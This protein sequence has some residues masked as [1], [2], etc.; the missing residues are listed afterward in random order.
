MSYTSR[1]FNS[2]TEIDPGY[3]A[4]DFAGYFDA[5]I[6]HGVVAGKEATSLKVERTTGLGVSV[7]VGMIIINGYMGIVHSAPEAFTLDS[8]GAQNRTDAVVMRLDMTV[9]ATGNARVG[10]I[11]PAV[12]KG[13]PGGG[14]PAVRRD[15]DVW[16]M[17]LALVTVRANA[18]S[19]A[20][21][22]VA[23]K[24]GDFDLCGFAAFMGEPAYYPPGD[25]PLLLWL[26]GTFPNELTPAQIS[27]VE[28][29][30]SLIRVSKP[31]AD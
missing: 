24:R 1:F 11:Y 28:S 16:E 21:G 12:V 18:S 17:C 19:L 5:L 9:D 2:T 10:S 6:R 3:G 25:I 15:N 31:P 13:T 14:A 26:Y 27:E 30:P 4:S 7:S 29:N 8:A 20:A 23:D 22:D